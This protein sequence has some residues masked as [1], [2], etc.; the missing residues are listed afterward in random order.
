MLPSPLTFQTP[1]N[2]TGPSF[3][4]DGG[5]AEKRKMDESE[6]RE[7]SGLGPGQAKRIKT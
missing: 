2:T 5:S 6:P 4:G 7:D 3:R 1:V